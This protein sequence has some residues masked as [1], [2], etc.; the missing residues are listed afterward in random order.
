MPKVTCVDI[1]RFMAY[2]LEKKIMHTKP[3]NRLLLLIA[4]LQ[5]RHLA[6][7]YPSAHMTVKG[8]GSIPVLQKSD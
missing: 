1:Y 2:Q 3:T 4:P 8:E 7:A 5:F 6:E